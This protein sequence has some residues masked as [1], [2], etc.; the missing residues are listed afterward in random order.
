MN[1]NIKLF[2]SKPDCCGCEACRNA[3]PKNA[4]VM[5]EDKEG[6]IYPEINREVCIGC[7]IC[8]KV[9]G[10]KKSDGVIP[11]KVFASSSK[12]SRILS[13]TASGGIF[14]VI[15]YDVLRRNGVVFGSAEVRTKNKLTA[16]HIMVDN[17][18][19]LHK[20]QGSKYVQSYIGDTYTEAK[21]YLEKGRT[22]LFSGTPCQIAGLNA[23]LRKKYDNLLTVDIICH[24][25]PNARMFNDFIDGYEKKNNVTVT[26]FRFRDKSRGQGMTNRIEY[27]DS[28]RK[29]NHRIMCGELNSYMGLFL[30]SLIYRENCYSCP[31]AR[32]ERVADITL[33]D[34]WGV[35]AEHSKELSRVPMDNSKGISCVL[36]N[37]DKGIKAFG[38]IRH[39]VFIIKSS[40]EKVERHNEQLSRPSSLPDNRRKVM[41][42]YRCSGYAGVEEY[43]RKLIGWKK[44]AYMVRFAL[45]KSLKRTVQI[46]ISGK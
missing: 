39:D 30:K 38:R 16:R 24:G 5:R 43:Y 34:Y 44:Y 9:C 15:A 2:E 45:P 17:A 18:D 27:T 26:D 46:L 31:F 32:N 4:I 7:G 40:L 13:G 35:Y 3:C 14:S 10:Y 28:G 8:K 12:D 22:V 19:D 41:E 37:T 33:G 29:K 6:F 36:L 23:F 11:R 21:K 42:I 25:V 20:L 1:G